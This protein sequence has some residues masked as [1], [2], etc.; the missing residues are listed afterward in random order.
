MNLGNVQLLNTLWQHS[1]SCGDTYEG[2]NAVLGTLPCCLNV[3]VNEDICGILSLLIMRHAA[4]TLLRRAVAE[5][6][7]TVAELQG[8]C[9]TDYAGVARILKLDAGLNEVVIAVKLQEIGGAA[10]LAM[11]PKDFASALSLTHAQQGERLEAFLSALKEVAANPD[12]CAQQQQAVPAAADT[13]GT[14]AVTA[15]K[16]KRRSDQ[17]TVAAAAPVQRKTPGVPK[18]LRGPRVSGLKR[19]APTAPVIESTAVSVAPI[20]PP[21]AAAAVQ[22]GETQMQQQLADPPVPHEGQGNNLGTD[23]SKKQRQKRDKRQSKQA[24]GKTGDPEVKNQPQVRRK[25]Q[26][27]QQPEA[28]SRTSGKSHLRAKL[29]AWGASILGLKGRFDSALRQKAAYRNKRA[30]LSTTGFPEG[31]GV[32]NELPTLVRRLGTLNG[33]PAAFEWKPQYPEKITHLICSNELVRPTVKLYFALVNGAFILK[34]EFLQEARKQKAW[35]DPQQFQRS[36]FPSVEQRD[37]SRWLLRSLPVCIDGPY[38]PSG[39]SKQQLQTLVLSAGGIL[40]DDA[41]ATVR[42]LEDLEALRRRQARGLWDFQG[43]GK[44]K[45]VAVSTQWLLDCIRSW[46]ML[47]RDNYVLSLSN[48]PPSKLGENTAEVAQKKRPKEAETGSSLGKKGKTGRG[49]KKRTDMVGDGC[50]G[51]PQSEVSKGPKEGMAALQITVEQPQGSLGRQ[52]DAAAESEENAPSMAQ[53]IHAQQEERKNPEPNPAQ[54]K[55]EQG[56]SAAKGVARQGMKERSSSKRL[57]SEGKKPSEHGSRKKK[58]HTPLP[59][60]EKQDVTVLRNASDALPESGS[61]VTAPAGD[62]AVTV[63]AAPTA[64]KQSPLKDKPTA[65]SPTGEGG[66]TENEDGLAASPAVDDWQPPEEN[67]PLEEG[68]AAEAVAFSPAAPAA[69]A[70]TDFPQRECP[71]STSQATAAGDALQLPGEHLDVAGLFEPEEADAAEYNFDLKDNCTM[72]QKLEDLQTNEPS[73]TQRDPVSAS[74]LNEN[75]PSNTEQ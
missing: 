36:D 16:K 39:L 60:E 28:A 45:P 50:E 10:L 9:Q 1:Y 12:G 37:K 30:L 14:A 72:G 29:M 7:V 66:C 44:Q 22:S 68:G 33:V 70:A 25:K 51:L 43:E 31:A 18:G 15:T 74:H 8:F 21:V 63:D 62:V 5:G 53:P 27:Q 20:S 38:R 59:A 42:V 40:E 54:P 13:A 67:S 35:P 52:P 32:Q 17:E 73:N 23:S 24:K 34:E 56:A 57:R 71:A 55:E 75:M 69:E 2:H 19:P 3:T 49:R 41:P 6:T 46:E 11:Q 4:E 61:E 26:Q 58:L 64:E 48:P 65:R 47:P